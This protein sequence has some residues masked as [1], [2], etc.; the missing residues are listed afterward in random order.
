MKSKAKTKKLLGIKLVPSHPSQK[1]RTRKVAKR[2]GTP[3]HQALKLPDGTTWPWPHGTSNY[4]GVEWK[5]RYLPPDKLTHSD[6]LQLAEI[7]S[8]YAFLIDS[9]TKFSTKA[10]RQLHQYVRNVW[11]FG[12]GEDE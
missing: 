8:A 1:S 12:H 7:A 6:I 5:A 3:G 11:K 2:I 10:L 4:N 9:S